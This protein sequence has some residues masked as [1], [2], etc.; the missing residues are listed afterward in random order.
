MR[1]SSWVSFPIGF[2]VLHHSF[3][4]LYSGVTSQVWNF[5]ANDFPDILPI[6]FLYLQEE[7][8][9]MG[10]LPSQKRLVEEKKVC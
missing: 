4:S 2:Y 7:T 5:S 3:L 8:G 1:S 9:K 10:G 6:V